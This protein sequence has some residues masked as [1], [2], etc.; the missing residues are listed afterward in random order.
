MRAAVM[1]IAIPGG[2]GKSTLV[3]K[4]PDIL[5]DIDSFWEPAAAAE[6][7][8][9]QHF[10]EARARGDEAEESRAITACML[11]K[12]HRASR[13][14]D[15]LSQVVLV[16]VPAQA[17]VLLSGPLN[18]SHSSF[19]RMVP[20]QHLHEA[21][22]AARGDDARIMT[23]CRDQRSACLNADMGNLKEYASF[24]ELET[25]VLAFAADFAKSSPS[26]AF[27]L[28]LDT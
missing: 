3:S 7:E 26:A 14:A 4:H 15:A 25:A 10:C 8:I 17:D 6:A 23:I 28:Q 24:E 1:V 13:S 5:S 12:A 19:L 2:G 16:Q 9:V 22:M 20:T 18:C 21:C 11:H 27:K